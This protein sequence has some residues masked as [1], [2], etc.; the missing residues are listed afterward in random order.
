[1]E[2]LWL[3]MFSV[4]S[5]GVLCKLLAPDVTARIHLKWPQQSLLH[6]I[7]NVVGAESYPA[8]KLAAAVIVH[9]TREVCD[10]RLQVAIRFTGIAKFT[11]GRKVDCHRVVRR[12]PVR[13]AACM[14]QN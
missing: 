12:T 11:A 2:C 10:H 1:M 13:E 6:E 3:T 14:H 7:A 5:G 9:M 4:R 8:F